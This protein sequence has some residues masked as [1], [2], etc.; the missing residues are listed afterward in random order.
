MI[1]EGEDYIPVEVKNEDD[2]TQNV[3]RFEFELYDYFRSNKITGIQMKNYPLTLPYSRSL[4]TINN[5]LAEYIDNLMDYWQFLLTDI[6]EF[7]QVAASC[8]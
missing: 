2:F 3:E 1:L 4:V 5:L 6:S 8:E 7:T